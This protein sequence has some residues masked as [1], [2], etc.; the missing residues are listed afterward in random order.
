MRL[1][2][3]L[4]FKSEKDFAKFGTEFGHA[5]GI[6]LI[7]INPSYAGLLAKAFNIPEPTDVSI[8]NYKRFLSQGGLI[9]TSTMLHSR[10]ENNAKIKQ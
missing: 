2:E 10:K 7:M 5:W 8:D 3:Q 6:T 4:G 9:P 1:Y